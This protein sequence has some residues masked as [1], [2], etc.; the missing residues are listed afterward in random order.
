MSRFPL[1]VSPSG[2]PITSESPGDV[3]TYAGNGEWEGKA[4]SAP[5]CQTVLL[6][7]PDGGEGTIGPIPYSW[8]QLELGRITFQHQAGQRHDASFGLQISGQAPAFL[9]ASFYI[10]GLPGQSGAITISPSYYASAAIPGR[11]S[12]YYRMS[13]VCPFWKSGIGEIPSGQYDLVLKI[14][15]IG[16]DSEDMGLGVYSTPS[17]NNAS[18]IQL[19]SWPMP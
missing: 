1:L 11:P 10:E 16:G 18:F 14:I 3:L 12:G 15:Q 9:E 5:V 7:K 2:Q 17:G 8:P 4:P 6:Y 19:V 13:G